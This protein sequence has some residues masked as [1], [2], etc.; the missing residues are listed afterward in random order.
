MPE[1][2]RNHKNAVTIGAG[3]DENIPKE[4]SGH[5]QHCLTP[6]NDSFNSV[7]L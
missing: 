4:Q 6:Y 3:P 2:T 7:Q 5:N 1:R